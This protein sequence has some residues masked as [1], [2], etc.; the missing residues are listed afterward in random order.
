MTLEERKNF[1]RS[2]TERRIRVHESREGLRA[3]ALRTGALR[4]KKSSDVEGRDKEDVFVLAEEPVG[5]DLA[6]EESFNPKRKP[7]KR[8]LSCLSF[9]SR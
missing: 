5:Q 1:I 6:E 9:W 7:K 8:R 3:E 2:N 4:R